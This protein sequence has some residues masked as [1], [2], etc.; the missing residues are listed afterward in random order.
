IGLRR[1][2]E[3][4]SPCLFRMTVVFTEISLRDPSCDGLNN[5]ETNIVRSRI[6]RMTGNKKRSQMRA[7]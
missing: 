2:S 7:F 3:Q 4:A 1:D 6:F 5:S